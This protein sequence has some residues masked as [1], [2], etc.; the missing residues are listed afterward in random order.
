M[1]LLKVPWT[2]KFDQLDRLSSSRLSNMGSLNLIEV[3]TEK[4]ITCSPLAELH[5]LWEVTN[6]LNLIHL[7]RCI[8]ELLRQGSKLQ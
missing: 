8:K 3:H 2:L 7:I 6:L 5:E 4:Q 1:G